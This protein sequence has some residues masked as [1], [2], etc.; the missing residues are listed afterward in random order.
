MACCSD[1]RI[2]QGRR[3]FRY[4][5]FVLPGS[6][7]PPSA[8]SPHSG[9][10]LSRGGDSPRSSSSTQASH[11][12]PA[13]P[14]PP[15]FTPG[16]IHRLPPGWSCQLRLVSHQDLEIAVWVVS[17]PSIPCSTARILLL[18]DGSCS[19]ASLGSPLTFSGTL[20]LASKATLSP[21]SAHSPKCLLPPFP[22]GG[23]NFPSALPSPHH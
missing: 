4:R 10:R 23:V 7:L 11:Q 1:I 22:R 9:S 14:A 21:Q 16:I 20:S 15:H 17:P 19:R 5:F 8:L 13:P 6:S 18:K 3:A 2:L 12:L